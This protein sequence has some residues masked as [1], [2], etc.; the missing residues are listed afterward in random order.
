MYNFVSERGR[1]WEQGYGFVIRF[2]DFVIFSVTG[3]YMY[4]HVSGSVGYL[5]YSVLYYRHACIYMYNSMYIYMYM[6]MHVHVYM[7]M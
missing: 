5:L 3:L 7:C 1:A 4:I 6:Y 2:Y